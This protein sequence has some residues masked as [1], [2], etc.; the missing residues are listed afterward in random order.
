MDPIWLDSYPPGV[1]VQI[2][3]DKYRNIGE[4][5]A[6]SAAR[7]AGSSRVRL[8]GKDAELRRDR[9][10]VSAAFGAYLQGELGLEKGARVAIMMPNVLQYPIAMLAVLRAGYTVV[11]CN[12]LYTP[13]ELG[14][15]LKDSGA[16]GDRDR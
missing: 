14:G 16:A 2:D 12:P 4:M 7:F 8:H 13:R 11:N 5:F 9:P 1:P 15:Q 10:A 3:P 6:E